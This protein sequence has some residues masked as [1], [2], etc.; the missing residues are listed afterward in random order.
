MHFLPLLRSSER[1]HDLPPKHDVIM[2]VGRQF[3]ETTKKNLCG[4]YT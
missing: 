4:K 2:M 1:K 3:W